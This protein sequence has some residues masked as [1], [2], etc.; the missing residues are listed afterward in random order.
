MAQYTLT[1]KHTVFGTPTIPPGLP[2]HN[3]IPVAQR[4]ARAQAVA[5]RNQVMPMS[6]TDNA[7][8]TIT[9]VVDGLPE[10]VCDMIA[11]WLWHG[12]VTV[13]SGG[14]DCTPA[15]GNSQEL[16]QS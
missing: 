15:L 6:I 5:R 8:G 4:R 12:N 11:A 14:P 9:W 10:D 2:G 1:L 3:P 16:Q 13:V 7:D